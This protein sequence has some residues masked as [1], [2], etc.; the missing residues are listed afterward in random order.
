MLDGKRVEGLPGLLKSYSEIDMR[1]ETMPGWEEDISKVKNFDDL[2]LNCRNYILR[3][4]ELIGVPIRWIGVGP[5]REDMIDRGS[6][7]T[8]A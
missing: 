7:K 4:E 8:K 6:H 3:L 1:F 2:P 5:D